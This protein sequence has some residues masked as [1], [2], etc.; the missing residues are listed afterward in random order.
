MKPLL[1]TIGVLSGLAFPSAL[2][3][4]PAPS[5]DGGRA[6]RWLVHAETFGRGKDQVT[7][8]YTNV[9]LTGSHIPAVIRRFQG[10]LEIVAGAAIN[11]RSYSIGDLGTTGA[12]T[13]SGEL[14]GLDPAISVH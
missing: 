3:A 5:V 14:A 10:K 7:F 1:A 11:G 13:V 2:F 6:G 8:Y 9:V 12:N 4:A